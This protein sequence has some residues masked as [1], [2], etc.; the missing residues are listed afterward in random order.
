MKNGSAVML[1]S[2]CYSLLDRDSDEWKN[3]LKG[4]NDISNINHDQFLRVLYNKEKVTTRQCRMGLCKT[5]EE[6]A[7]LSVDKLSLNPNFIKLRVT[8]DLVTVKPL[9]IGHLFV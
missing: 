7:V 3:A 2:K 8:D 6:K 5:L 4:V 9:K 1:S